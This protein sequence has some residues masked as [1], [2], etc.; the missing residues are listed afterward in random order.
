MSSYREILET[1]DGLGD[2]RARMDYLR[3]QLSKAWGAGYD[4]CYGDGG[5]AGNPHEC[6]RCL[7]RDPRDRID[8]GHTLW[9]L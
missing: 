3:R 8:H 1:L 9:Y 4:H 5:D 7:D 6:D 2:E